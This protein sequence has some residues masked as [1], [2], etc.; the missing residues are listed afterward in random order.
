[1]WGLEGWRGFDKRKY[2]RRERNDGY[3]CG[4]VGGRKGLFGEM[5]PAGKLAQRTGKGGE[6]GFF[7]GRG[8]IA[9]GENEHACFL[10]SKNPK[11]S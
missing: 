5:E 7:G 2:T 6:R 3:F 1:M 11:R 10:F 9:I 4:F 8:R